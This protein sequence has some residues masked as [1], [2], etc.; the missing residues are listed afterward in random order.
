MTSTLEDRAYTLIKE[1]I[2]MATPSSNDVFNEEMSLIN[3][4]IEGYAKLG[5]IGSEQRRQL[6][7]ML[8]EKGLEYS[9]M[10]A[11]ERAHEYLK[12]RKIMRSD[13]SNN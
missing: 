7:N 12:I 10:K 11:N 8:V 3:W 2:V 13:Y 6:S 4:A 1:R 9:A 5:K